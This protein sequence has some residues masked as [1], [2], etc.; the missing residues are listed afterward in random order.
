MILLTLSLEAYQAYSRTFIYR[1]AAHLRIP[2]P[3][4]AEEEYRIAWGLSHAASNA[5]TEDGI[6]KKGDEGRRDRRGRNASASGQAGALS[7]AHHVDIAEIGSLAG[8]HGLGSLATA[9]VLGNMGT[10]SD[11]G[12]AVCVFFGMCGPRGSVAKTLDIFTKDV[13]DV[14]LVPLHG[15]QMLQV[16]EGNTIEPAERRLRLTI[17]INGWLSGGEDASSPWRTLGNRSEAYTLNWEQ[18]TLSKIGAS[19]NT[20]ASSVAWQN[21]RK[22]FESRNRRLPCCTHPP[23]PRENNPETGCEA[24]ICSNQSL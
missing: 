1:I 20:V 22:D 9:T 7:L 19:I 16:R 8:G 11:G 2:Q 17:G 4:V 24:N 12:L 13:Q 10:L 21:A 14:A 5:F 23:F 18:E 3:A 6:P 15:A